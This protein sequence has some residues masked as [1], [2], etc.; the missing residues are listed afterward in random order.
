M[1]KLTNFNLKMDDLVVLE[2]VNFYFG[3]QTYLLGG[4]MFKRKSLLVDVLA[5]GFT[6]YQDGVEYI[7]ESGIVYL[8]NKKILIENLTVKQNLDFFAKFFNTSNI[9]SRVIIN[10]FELDNILDRRVNT[11]TPDMIQLARISCTMLNVNASVYLLDNIFDR[12]NKSQI[13]LVKDYLK[14]VAS[15][16][17]I[18]FAKLNTHEIEEFNPRIITINQK[19]LVYGEV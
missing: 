1:I 12:L 13:D 18:I 9:K 16:S 6:T 17:I 7:A 4:S 5:E 14:L 11:L 10:H 8:P 2:D 15:K 19:K 3:H